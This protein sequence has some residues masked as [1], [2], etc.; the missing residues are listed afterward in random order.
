MPA[1]IVLACGEPLSQ[2]PIELLRALVG[3]VVDAELVEQELQSF[4]IA[5]VAP[6]TGGPA[7]RLSTTDEKLELA[8]AKLG[9]TEIV[10]TGKPRALRQV[11]GH[12]LAG[13][14]SYEELFRKAPPASKDFSFEFLS[15]TCFRHGDVDVPLPLSRPLFN[16]L[17]RRWKHSHTRFALHEDVVEAAEHHLAIAT[18]RIE[19]QTF[20]EDKTTR[21]GFVGKVTF[22]VSGSVNRDILHEL[23]ALADFAFYASV[24]QRTQV[25]MGLIRRLGQ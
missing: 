1:A 21:T 9:E 24:G 13:R 6:E 20:K 25:G 22:R 17:Y 18:L 19:S 2:D 7:F 23:N 14:R 5:S 3:R 4:T 16:G 10:V 8:I 11:D 15:P 12:P